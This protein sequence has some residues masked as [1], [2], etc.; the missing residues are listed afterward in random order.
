MLILNLSQ[1]RFQSFKVPRRKSFAWGL[2]VLFILAGILTACGPS[3]HPAVT[4]VEAYLQALVDK[5]ETRLI[6]LASR[7]MKKLPCW[8]WILSTW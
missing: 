8:S 4:T 6:S 5:D 3:K 1:F 7:I 2:A